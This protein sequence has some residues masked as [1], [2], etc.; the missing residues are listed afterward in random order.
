MSAVYG[1]LKTLVESAPRYT[2]LLADVEKKQHPNDAKLLQCL[3]QLPAS[4]KIALLCALPN[5]P[6]N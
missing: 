1:A 4:P 5:I 2:A 3:E 6:V